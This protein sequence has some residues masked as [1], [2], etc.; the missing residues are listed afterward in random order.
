MEIG[1]ILR[2]L[3]HNKLGAMLIAVQIAVTMT[4]I[5]NAI[6]IINER[7]R[8]MTRPSGLE[9]ANLFHL[10]SVGYGDDFNEQVTSCL[11]YTSPSPRD[12]G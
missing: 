9:E 5:I 2:A 12:R 8:L 11:L 10:T 4:V 1:P 7:S 6:F 3:W